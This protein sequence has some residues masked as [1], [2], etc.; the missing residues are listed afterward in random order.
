MSAYGPQASSS[1]KNHSIP[2]SR[3]ALS[4]LL[5][6]LA[7]ATGL[8]AGGQNVTGDTGIPIKITNFCPATI[9][10]ALATQEGRG[11]TTHGFELVSQSSK[12]L[13]VSQDWQGRVWAR[14][15]CSFNAEG[16]AASDGS[17]KAC[18]TGDCNGILDCVVTVRPPCP[19]PP[20][21]P[22]STWF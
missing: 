15:N 13:S 21:P 14:T 11:P 12:E 18:D 8:E 10:P 4:S 1:Q 19:L 9:W 7:A 20:P 17:R 5:L 16:T 3:R 22:S 6:L 2:A